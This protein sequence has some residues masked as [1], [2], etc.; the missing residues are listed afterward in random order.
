M[1]TKRRIKLR[2]SIKNQLKDYKGFG[3]LL[4]GMTREGFCV[5][6]NGQ[7]VSEKELEKAIRG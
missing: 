2:I 6:S 7:I 5:L 3:K 1:A 4:N